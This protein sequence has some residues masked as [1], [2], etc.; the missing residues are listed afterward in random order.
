MSAFHYSSQTD[1]KAST[2]VYVK[3]VHTKQHTTYTGVVPICYVEDSDLRGQEVHCY[4]EYKKKKFVYTKDDQ[5]EYSFKSL[6]FPEQ[7]NF[8]HYKEQKGYMKNREM[9]LAEN[10]W[11]LNELDIPLPQFVDI[12]KEHMVAPFFVFQIFCTFLWL[13]DEYWYYSLFTL[14]L[15]MFAESTVVF[16][17]KKNME[18]LRS[19][20]IHPYDLHVLRKGEW[21]L[22]SSEHLLPG[23]ICLLNIKPKTKEDK[24]KK[25]KKDKK[26]EKEQKTYIPCDILVLHGNGIV[27]ESIL[28][29]ESVPQVK[30]SITY[31]DSNEKLDVLDKHKMHILNGGTELVQTYAM[32]DLPKHIPPPPSEGI[33]GYVIRNGFATKKG[34]LMR[35][36]LDTTGRATVESKEAYVF[37]FILFIFA[38]ISSGYVLNEGLKD[39]ARNKYKLLLRCIIILTS[40]VPPELPME[41]S[42]AVN[43][44]MME[45]IKK[46]I[47]C[48]EPFRMPLAGMIDVCCYDKTGTL[49]SDELIVEGCVGVDPSKGKEIVP[50]KSIESINVNTIHIIGGCHTLAQVDDKLIGDPL[51]KS[52]FDAIKW[53][54]DPNSNAFQAVG[55]RVRVINQKKFLFDSTLK[56]MTTISLVKEGKGTKLKVLSKGAPEVLQQLLR[57][58]PPNYE[59]YYNYY[60]KHG[61][62]V[63]A[64]GYKGLPESIKARDV[65]RENAEK[66]LEFAGFLIFQCPMKEDT[67]ENV[68]KI[69]E[70]DCKVKIITGD[71]ILTAAYV[72][73][74]LR[75]AEHFNEKDKQECVVF[76]K[77]DEEKKCI[78]WMDYDDNLISSS[79]T[80]HMNFIAIE[81]M[82]KNYILCLGG[83]ELDLLQSMMSVNDLSNLVLHVHVFARTSP[84]QKDLIIRMINK[85][86]R[87]TAMCGDGTNDVG[88]LKSATIGIAVLNNKMQKKPEVE[89]KKEEKKEEDKVAVPEEEKVTSPFY[90]PT[91]N[92][93]QTLTMEQIRKKQQDRMQLY[94]KQNKKKKGMPNFN[95]FALMDSHMTELGDACIAAPFTYKFSSVQCVNTVIC[96]GRATITTTYQMYKILALNSM[97]SAY[98]MSTL[99]LDGV[100]N[101]DFQM[102]MLGMAMGVLFLLISLSKPLETLSKLRPP[103]SI[104]APSIV[105]SV[106]TQFV[107]HFVTLVYI[108]RETDPFIVRDESTEPDTDFKPNLKN[109]VVF[110]YSWTMAAT[111]FLVNY[112]GSPFMQS[113]KE[114]SKLYKGIL[115]MYAIALV[116][117]LDIFDFVRE[118]LE[119]VPF[120]NDTIQ[121][122][123]IIALTVDTLLC[124][125]C[126][127]AIKRVSRNLQL[128][129]Q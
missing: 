41:L 80:K 119:L 7:E 26:D 15:L 103:K 30:E 62:R 49:T 74:K 81:K 12:F 67:F 123:I 35:T 105:L 86:G 106:L 118:N 102:T 87:Y 10:K 90:W 18:R 116:A 43:Y 66:D 72:A 82:S 115:A 121:T 13:M 96:Q 79:H 59:E 60:V 14:A 28:T 128:S 40:V 75:I 46:S 107:F 101:G 33:I 69:M 88:S 22:I 36:I 64:M 129:S 39:E 126:C 99:W 50:I 122:K 56:R 125:G 6:K 9:E 63:I 77:I 76:A 61:Y 71:N 112:E 120:P 32:P 55:G 5:G 110:L 11:G 52:A 124:I 31:R 68:A 78:N 109:N 95:D 97:I 53:E 48:T 20:R 21:K 44:S 114:N 34:K 27:D 89:E 91:A 38:C 65:S 25:D 85:L 2:H 117:I 108:V 104:F 8:G 92:E 83:K 111:T 113:F 51:E 127:E 84:A 98:S 24:D 100:K 37:L 4:I 58:V 17:R 1:L 3:A 47:F 54:V 42:L 29:G 73:V 16:Q 93:M 45:I 19:M 23:D 70:A 57:E 94:M